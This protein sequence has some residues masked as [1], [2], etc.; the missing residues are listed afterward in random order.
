MTDQHPR[1][2]FTGTSPAYWRCVE[3]LHLE[4]DLL[5]NKEFQAWLRLLDADIDYRIPV[6]FTTDHGSTLSPFSDTG[7]HLIGGWGSLKARLERLCTDAA[8][9]EHPPTRT[10]RLVTNVQVEAGDDEGEFRVRSSFLFYRARGDA[11]P[12]ILCGTRNDILREHSGELRL[13]KRTVLLDQVALPVE[14][15]STPL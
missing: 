10:R 12:A 7:F 1:Q 5:D 13:F 3:F 11:D 9:S 4:A 8:W 14:A 2:R 15:I 6:R